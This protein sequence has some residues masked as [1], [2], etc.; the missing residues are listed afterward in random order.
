MGFCPG[1]KS[2]HCSKA[3]KYATQMLLRIPMLKG[4]RRFDHSFNKTQ[5]SDLDSL[6]GEESN[7][8]ML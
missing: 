5:D 2:I 6:L 3:T 1:E 7:K 4:R 8:L